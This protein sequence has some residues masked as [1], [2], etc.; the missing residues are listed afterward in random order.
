MAEKLPAKKR[1]IE[2][3][4][5][6]AEPNWNKCLCHITSS[7]EKLTTFTKKS[8]GKFETCSER[9]QDRIWLIM[10]NHWKK[11][12]KGGYHRQCYQ[13]Y[14]NVGH[15]SR[16]K[17]S[18]RVKPSSSEGSSGEN[19]QPLSKRICRSQSEGFD[20]QKC[21]ICQK[22]KTIR[23]SNGSRKKETL[24]QNI[25]EYGSATLLR[26]AQIKKDRQILLQIEGQDTIALEI[27][28]HRSCY[29]NYVKQET[30]TKLEE[31]NRSSQGQESTG[32]DVEDSTKE[33]SHKEAY[34]VFSSS[35]LLRRVLLDVKPCMAWPPT[36]DDLDSHD[37]MIPDLL[38]N[39]LA[40]ILSSKARF[41]TAR[42]SNI[43][44][45]VHRLV[46]S[47][48]QD[49]IHCVSRGRIKTPKHVLLPTT[50]K[51]LTGNAEV[52]SILNRFGHGLSYSQIEELETSM[53]EVQITKEQGGIFIPSS[54][55]PDVPGVFCW[56]NNDLQEETLSG[57]YD[58]YVVRNA[59]YRSFIHFVK[60]FLLV[61]RE[62]YNTL[63]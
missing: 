11:G 54:C 9:R 16:I 14:T 18:S 41:S 6:V 48:A 13:K 44:S 60:G 34:Q 29:K 3:S 31:G 46:L 12:P 26:A 40:W 50:V 63:H 27:K 1:P 57:R 22:E 30:L 43:S 42:V 33:L 59:I 35:K 5:T 36:L 51:S 62:R 25:S 2:H 52:I 8:W 24:S 10:N 56:D 58:R 21:I 38:Y 7:H 49:L 15:L 19:G 55:S 53:A 32:S 23:Q 37:A 17:C 20:I 4:T 45:K 28:Y 39:M 61:S 47:L